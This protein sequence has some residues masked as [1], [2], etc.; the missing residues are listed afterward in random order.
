MNAEY[1]G[2]KWICRLVLEVHA[3]PSP[4]GLPESTKTVPESAPAG[5]PLLLELEQA[6]TAMAP[7]TA[8]AERAVNKPLLIFSERMADSLGGG[9]ASPHEVRHPNF[10]APAPA[11]LDRAGMTNE[12]RP[13]RG[14]GR[15]WQVPPPPAPMMSLAQNDS[16]PP[17]PPPKVQQWR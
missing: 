9:N 15:Y 13:A 14:V 2:A 16:E 5:V 1:I 12:T 8:A 10:Q 11:T 4:D 6:T 3:P 17:S 7:T